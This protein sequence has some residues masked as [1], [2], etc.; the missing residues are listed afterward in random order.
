MYLTVQ[1]VYAPH[2]GVGINGAL[3]MHD[4]T[5]RD[6]GWNPPDLRLVVEGNL[7][8]QVAARVDI[9]PGGNAV[10]AFLD[11]VAPDDVDIVKLREALTTFGHDLRHSRQ[12]ETYGSIVVE[13]SVNLADRQR[14][15]SFQELSSAAVDLLQ[16]PRSVALGPPLVISVSHDDVGWHFTLTEESAERLKGSF[17]DIQIARVNVPDNVARDFRVMYGE[18]YP[19]AVEWVTSKPRSEL[20]RLGGVRIV[21]GS[22]SVW[23]WP[24]RHGAG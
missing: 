24:Q 9:S 3:Y 14:Q 11:I 20:L 2:R 10:H 16:K 8:R 13:F 7:G 18:L 12:Q 1:K 17:P 19:H 6:P 5:G 15:E 4:A 21:H 22:Q 23:E